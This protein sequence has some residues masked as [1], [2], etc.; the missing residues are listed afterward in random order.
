MHAT[1]S[2]DFTFE[3]WYRRNEAIRAKHC[4]ADAERSHVILKA[5]G[6]GEYIRL[7]ART[8][9]KI[10][11]EIPYAELLVC[12]KSIFASRLS[13]FRRRHD[14]LLE[15]R[16][17]P[18]LS[19][20]ELVDF[21]NLKGDNF[22]LNQFKFFILLLSLSE[23]A[24]KCRA[25]Y[26]EGHIAKVCRSKRRVNCVAANFVST[27]ADQASGRSHVCYR[28]G[29][30][31]PSA[32]LSTISA[33]TWKAVGWPTLQ[34]YVE[35]CTQADGSGLPSMGYFTAVLSTTISSAGSRY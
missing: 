26:Q 10:P 27:V 17:P 11:E 18:G 29:R 8:S 19:G 23:D 6:L 22:E 16:L 31:P 28:G 30:R 20:E 15:H 4:E 14:I 33:S 9:P 7:R 24:N 34:S 32:D 12:L 1:P 35:R 3:H 5:L 21:A 13:L 2:K 25:C